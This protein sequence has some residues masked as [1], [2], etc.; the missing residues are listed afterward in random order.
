MPFRF[1]QAACLKIILRDEPDFVEQRPIDR[2]V[3]LVYAVHTTHAGQPVAEVDA[4]L[5]RQFV[6]AGFTPEEPAFSE[7]VRAIA[8]SD[9]PD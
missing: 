1:E 6:E 3:A 7:V 5:R 9:P 8:Q 4:E 2:V